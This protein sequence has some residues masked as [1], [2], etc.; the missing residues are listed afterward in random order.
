MKKCEVLDNCLI[1]VGKGSIVYIS[2]R[3]YEIARKKFKLVEEKK[4]EEKPE[5]VKPVEEVK[6]I[7]TAALPKAKKTRKAKK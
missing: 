1:A 4:K 5:E 2:D 7:E 3:Q 6:P